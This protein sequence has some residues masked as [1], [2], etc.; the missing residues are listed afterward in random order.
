MRINNMENFDT[1]IG[2]FGV[3]QNVLLTALIITALPAF[4]LNMYVGGIPMLVG[5]YLFY[6]YVALPLTEWMIEKIPRNYMFHLIEWIV[7]MN[8]LYVTNDAN[9]I[10]MILPENAKASRAN[11]F[12]RRP[13]MRADP[14]QF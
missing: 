11:P 5:G 9:P 3:N 8:V 1:N 10:P 6:K 7:T 4:V 12:E 14:N 2:A 13:L